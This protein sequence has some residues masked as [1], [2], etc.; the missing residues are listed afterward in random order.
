MKKGR[1]NKRTIVGTVVSDKMD[2]TVT[3]LWETRKKHRLYKKFVKAR[4]KIKAHDEKNEA[5][6]GDLVKV[7]E[8]RPISK[9]KSWRLVEILE[10]AQRG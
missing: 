5:G 6:M 4:T 1:P 7:V 10:K 9:E 3:V 2:K 8:A